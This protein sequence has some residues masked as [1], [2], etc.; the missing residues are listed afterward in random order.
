MSN[1]KY[2]YQL[3]ELERAD[4]RTSGGFKK[5]YID[6]EFFKQTNQCSVIKNPANARAN[7]AMLVHFRKLSEL[8]V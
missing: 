2:C 3:N 1:E 5:V 4:A 8:D 6:I 7:T